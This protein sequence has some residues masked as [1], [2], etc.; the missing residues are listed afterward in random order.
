MIFGLCL[1]TS[2]RLIYCLHRRS[3]QSRQVIVPYPVDAH[4]GDVED[5]DAPGFVRCRH[6]IAC[7]LDVALSAWCIACAVHDEVAVGDRFRDA[8]AGLKLRLRPLVCRVRLRRPR[9]PAHYPNR[10]PRRVPRLSVLA[11]SLL[12]TSTERPV[13]RDCPKAHP[14]VHRPT[15]AGCLEGTEMA[16]KRHAAR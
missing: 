13:R 1:D 15:H 14:L 12:V 2:A 9:L 3:S 5:R 10:V 7:T 6:K 11:A 8:F 16:T 4:D